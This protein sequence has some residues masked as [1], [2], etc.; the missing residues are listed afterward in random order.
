MVHRLEFH[1]VAQADLRGIYDHIDAQS[2]PERAGAFIERIEKACASLLNFPK[3]GVP[4]DDVAP[5]LRT[6]ALERRALIVYRVYETHVE[7]L[8][9][10]YAGRDF[11]AEE[12]SH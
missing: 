6:W 3:K 9:V 2:G 12:I 10:L 7:I 4:R 5:G 11:R 8:S 1:R